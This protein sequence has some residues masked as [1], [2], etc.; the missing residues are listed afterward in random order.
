MK[1][2]RKRYHLLGWSPR[3]RMKDWKGYF[4][5]FFAHF[6]LGYSILTIQKTNPELQSC[7]WKVGENPFNIRKLSPMKVIK[8]FN[9]SEHERK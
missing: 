1:V 3:D 7:L 9:L 5:Q 2:I 6:M 4:E 8:H